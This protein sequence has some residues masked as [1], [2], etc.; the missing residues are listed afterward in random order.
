MKFLIAYNNDTSAEA[1][2]HFSFCGEEMEIDM[3][4]QGLDY[5]VLTPPFLTN[6]QLL[7]NLPTCQVCFVAN[8]G[9]SKS[10]AGDNG[11]IVSVDTDNS[12]FSGKLLYAVSCL[13]AKELKDRLVEDGLRSFWGYD[14]KLKVW[15]GYPQYAR[16]CMAGIKSLIDGKTIKDAKDEM[17]SQYNTGISELEEQ[18]PNAPYLA[19]AL[20]DNREAL[21][22]YGDDDL[23]LAD[24]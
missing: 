5:V 2:G 23:K 20:L 21:V 13:C 9:D 11:D 6:A 1:G 22:V 3:L 18:Y 15:Y 8:H 16:S 17:I 7:Q 10:I 14:N 19:A 24:L 4:D 12:L